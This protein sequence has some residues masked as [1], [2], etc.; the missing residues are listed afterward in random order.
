[1]QFLHFLLNVRWR[2]LRLFRTADFTPTKG[3]KTTTDKQEKFIVVEKGKDTS[4]RRG[5]VIAD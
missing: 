1:M 5:K 4:G 2:G 3:E